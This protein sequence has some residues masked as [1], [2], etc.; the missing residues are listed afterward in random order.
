MVDVLH[1]PVLVDDH[2]GIHGHDGIGLEAANDAHQ[3][4]AQCQVVLEGAVRAVQEVD[5]FV[6]DDL[7]CGTLFRPRVR[8]SSSGVRRRIVRPSVAARA[9]HHARDRT[10]ANPARHRAGDAEVGIVGVGDDHEDAVRPLLVGI[11]ISHF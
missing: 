2:R 5:P 11:R 4:L 9:A 6:A 10:R 3:L 1:E 7:C 8:A